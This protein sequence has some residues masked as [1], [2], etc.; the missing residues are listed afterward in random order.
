MKKKMIITTYFLLY[1]MLISCRKETDAKQQIEVT[2]ELT[3]EISTTQTTSS[4]DNTVDET[5]VTDEVIKEELG[6][7]HIL[8]T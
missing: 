3:T 1:C 6:R 4:Q 5:N 7:M 2:E 8:S